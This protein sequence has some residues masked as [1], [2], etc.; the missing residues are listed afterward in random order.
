MPSPPPPTG[1]L[2]DVKLQWRPEAALT[3]VMAAKGYP[4]S[5]PRGSVIRGLER[6]KTAKVRMRRGGSAYPAGVGPCWGSC[7]MAR[8]RVLRTWDVRHVDQPQSGQRM[9]WG[10]PVCGAT[11][12]APIWAATYHHHRY[13][14]S[15]ACTAASGPFVLYTAALSPLLPSVSLY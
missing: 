9:S 7:C 11:A 15:H 4:G 6:V 12:L 3:V 1:K 10:P 14:S 13:G 8:P 2:H 5:Y